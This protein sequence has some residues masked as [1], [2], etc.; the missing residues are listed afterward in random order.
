MKQNLVKTGINGLDKALAGGIPNESLVLLT[1]SP[2]TG[3]TILTIQYLYNGATKYNDNCLF[4][5]FEQTEEDIQKQAMQFGWNLSKL[6]KNNKLIIWT[7]PANRIERDTLPTLVKLIKKNNVKRVAI[8][9]ISTLSFNTPTIS[10]HVRNIGDIAVKRFMYDFLHKLKNTKATTI[11]ISQNRNSSLSIDGVSEFICD[12]IINIKFQ[13]MGGEYSRSLMVQ[14]MR[15]S[16]N[17]D[18][19]HPMEISSS[20]IKIHSI[21]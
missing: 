17:N 9:S 5:S 7:L 12:G 19:L 11:L 8:D 3:K 21:E 1:G 16:K 14:K 13:P 18:D 4:I 2:G 10:D 6:S 20:G 15:N